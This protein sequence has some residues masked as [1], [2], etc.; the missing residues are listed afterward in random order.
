MYEIKKVSFRL[1]SGSESCTFMSECT[2]HE[3]VIWIHKEAEIMW[4]IKAENQC[5][6]KCVKELNKNFN[7]K[8]C[9]YNTTHMLENK[10]EMIG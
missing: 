2:K 3:D 1:K 10:I 6:C 5:T 7:L 9:S 8:S 4:K